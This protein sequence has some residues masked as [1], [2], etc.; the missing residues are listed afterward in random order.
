MAKPSSG[1]VA[2]HHKAAARRLGTEIAEIL[3]RGMDNTP[4]T[5]HL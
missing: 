2:A 1:L 3:L 5:A 4:N